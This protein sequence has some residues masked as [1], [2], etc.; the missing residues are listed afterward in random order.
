MNPSSNSPA[1]ATAA[2]QRANPNVEPVLV[3]DAPLRVFHWMMA[4]TFIGAYL[5]AED[6]SWRTVHVTLG[7]TM[8]GLVA[9]R[10]VWGLVGS[11]WA[12][13]SSFVR[14]PAGVARY[15]RSIL[16]R[17]PE[18][19]TGHNPAGALA[20]MA[21]LALTIVVTATG[22]M[23]YN[24]TMGKWLEESHEVLANL[25]LVV[26]GVHVVGVI[27]GSWLHRENLAKAMVTGYKSGAP[28]DGIR[29]A[30]RGI[31][32]LVAAAV[33]AYWGLQWQ[34]AA[35]G[36]ASSPATSHTDKDHDGDD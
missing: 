22:W 15:V 27:A 4:A 1:A 3:W 28:D 23:T 12:R 17:T 21:L 10:L 14:G 19:H 30:R 35:S 36:A 5:T 31:A 7:Y 34:G 18:H 11:R 13:F 9:F 29:H 32:V 8:A 16:E 26:V 25:M 24:D 2:G 33:L 6:E 20:I